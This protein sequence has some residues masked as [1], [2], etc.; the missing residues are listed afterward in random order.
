[1]LRLFYDDTPREKS[2]PFLFW[3]NTVKTPE[4]CPT[5]LTVAGHNKVGFEDVLYVMKMTKKQP[6]MLLINTLPMNEQEYLIQN[7]ISYQMEEKMINDLLQDYRQNLDHYTIILY[8]KHA[9]DDTVDKK[10]QQLLKLG[11]KR[12]FIYYGG[13]FEW[14]LLQDIYGVEHFPTTG[15]TCK[16]LLAFSAS[17]K[18]TKCLA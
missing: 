12:V 15:G 18:L 11:F 1:M 10:Y 4:T 13:L 2:N 7:T 9:A 6:H 14:Y 16:D 5:K 17:S 3:K 8:G